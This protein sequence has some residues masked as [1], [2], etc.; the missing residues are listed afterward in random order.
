[1]SLKQY[2]HSFQDKHLLSR[3]LLILNPNYPS[4]SQTGRSRR[5]TRKKKPIINVVQEQHNSDSD[6]FSS[7]SSSS[8]ADH[9]VTLDLDNVFDGHDDE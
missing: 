8:N 2:G 9:T 4:S 3:L 6:A 7:S 5:P 1:M